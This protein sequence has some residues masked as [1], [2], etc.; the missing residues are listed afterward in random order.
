[1]PIREYQAA[2]PEKGCEK[3]RDPFERL[4]PIAAPKLEHCPACGAKLVRLLSAPRLGASQSSFDARAKNAGFKK[5]QKLSK[6]E[7]EVKY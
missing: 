6:G 2:A 1:M 4:E 5:L 7:Y 3:C